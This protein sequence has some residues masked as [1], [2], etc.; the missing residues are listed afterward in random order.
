[1]DMYKELSLNSQL[2]SK[3]KLEKRTNQENHPEM[4]KVDFESID[5]HSNYLTPRSNLKDEE[6]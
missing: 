5:R 6:L 3:F 2:A 1:M 4:Y